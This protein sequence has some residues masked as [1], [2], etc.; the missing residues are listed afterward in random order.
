MTC[1]IVKAYDYDLSFTGELQWDI[2]VSED[3]EFVDCNVEGDGIWGIWK[4][5]DEDV[6]RRAAL[7]RY[8]VW[9]KHYFI[10]SFIVS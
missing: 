4:L 5:A 1:G 10:S 9:G 3:M 2:E 7:K 6:Y 8:R